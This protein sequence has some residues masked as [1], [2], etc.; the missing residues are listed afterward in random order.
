MNDDIFSNAAW[1]SVDHNSGYGPATIPHPRDAEIQSLLSDWILLEPAIRSRAAIALSEDQ[2][3]TLLAFSERMA[4]AA[5]RTKNAECIFYGLLALGI[6]GW[7]SDW[8]DNVTLL[9]LHYN[10]SK[11]L[12][13]SPEEMFSKAGKILSEAVAAALAA[14][15]KRSAEDKALDSMGYDEGSDDGGFRYKRTW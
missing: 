11:K 2:Q 7:L 1:L 12:G 15:L 10:A 3:F 4:S 13:I 9:C 14:F 5:I 8:R 6:D